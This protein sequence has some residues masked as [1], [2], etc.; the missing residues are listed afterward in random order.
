MVITIWPNGAQVFA[1][2]TMQ[3]SWGLDDYNVPELRSSRLNSAAM[4]ITRNVLSCF[5]MAG[6]N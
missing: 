3:W 4:Q 5:V 2:G 6:H 1:T